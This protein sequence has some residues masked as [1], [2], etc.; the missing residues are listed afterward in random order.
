MPPN[1]DIPDQGCREAKKVENH[2][3]NDFKEISGPKNQER[4]FPSIFDVENK[5]YNTT[6]TNNDIQF[7]DFSF[8]LCLPVLFQPIFN[9]DE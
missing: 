8:F 3:I 2:W 5:S 1:I 4:K 9:L 6:S 7:E